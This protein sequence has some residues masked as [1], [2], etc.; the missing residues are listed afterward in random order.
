MRGEFVGVWSETWREIWQPLIDPPLGGNDEALRGDIFCELYREISKALRKPTD[1]TVI[2]LLLRDAIALWELFDGAAQRA[3][4]DVAHEL[5]RGAFDKSGAELAV[6]VEERR[7][8]V[9]AA[10]SALLGLAGAPLL[11]AQVLEHARD[12]AKVKAAWNRAVEKT[13]NDAEASRKSFENIAAVDLGGEGPVVGFFE[14]VHGTLEQF[15]KAGDDELTNRYFNLLTAFIEKF[16]LRYDLRRP[17]VICPTL[18][19]IFVSLVRALD[20]LANTDANVA[21]R[22]RDFKEALQD[23]RL[24]STEAR[25]GNCVA[26]QVMLLE[27]IASAGGASGTDLAALCKAVSDWP[28][29]AVRSSLLSLYG[30]ASDFPGLRHGT[31][32]RGMARDLDMRD[33][34]A[35]S[36][37][38]TGFTPHLTRQLSADAI[39]GGSTRNVSR[40][41]V[42]PPLSIAITRISARNSPR[43]GRLRGLLDRLR[44]RSA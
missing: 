21:R 20:D 6:T 9:E 7:A 30:F 11:D 25:M 14:A 12:D 16:S 33:I 29:P 2:D 31:P 19:G 36:I 43:R 26:K 10:L 17:C 35:M 27:A 1:S 37:L 41:L 24:G 15:E 40:V 28:H 42:G 22:L 13:I 32:S 23:L 18:P 4:K 38:L 44:G 3:G 39:Y 34:V 8:R 5:V